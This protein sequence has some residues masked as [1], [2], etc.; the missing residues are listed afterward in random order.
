MI[1]LPPLPFVGAENSLISIQA[2]F[3]VIQ[4]VTLAALIFYNYSATSCEELEKLSQ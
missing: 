4:L 1:F 2:V 3:T